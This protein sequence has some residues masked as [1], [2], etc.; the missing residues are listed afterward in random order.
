MKKYNILFLLYLFFM[1]ASC[2]TLKEGFKNPKKNSSDEFLVKKKSPL[3]MP[4]DFNE[5]PVPN[6][7]TTST[8]TKSSDI[9]EL[10]LDEKNKITIE[11]GNETNLE[12]SLLEQIKN[13]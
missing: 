2:G 5:L 7:N 13:Q 1:V 11:S 12:K 4:P 10:I 3:V 9:K 8:E 6:S